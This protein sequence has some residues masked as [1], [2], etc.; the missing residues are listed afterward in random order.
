MRLEHSGDISVAQGYLALAQQ[1]EGEGRDALA[2][3]AYRK[4]VTAAPNEASVHH[5][6]GLFL[7]TRGRLDGGIAAIRRA[8]EL[9]PE[10][11]QVLNNLGYALLASGHAVAARPL[12][13]RA[14][15][16]DSDYEKARRNLDQVERLIAS[17][18]RK[19]VAG[20]G[21]TVTN[22]TSPSQA[23]AVEAR[24]AAAT[25]ELPPA[26]KM[27]VQTAPSTAA[28]TVQLDS[29]SAQP[30]LATVQPST[31]ASFASTAATPIPV[32]VRTAQIDH[33][34]AQILPTRLAESR[35][36]Y[37]NG[38]G[39]EGLAARLRTMMNERG[40]DG[41]RL[42]NL[43][44]YRTSATVIHYRAGHVGA[45]EELARRMPIA[46]RIEANAEMAEDVDLR[47]VIGH[48][49]RHAS[50]CE[51]LAVCSKQ[52]AVQV[53]SRAALAR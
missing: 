4:A 32:A 44:P 33:R 37:V 49:V 36:Q 3:D 52:P 19:P 30:V 1:L 14:L 7:A 24:S 20:G 21:A 42:A 22:T 18:E 34:S 10:R 25:A 48:D 39:V 13:E 41:G 23:P 51:A 27:A 2:L 50:A 9:E 28:L 17:N 43:R 40:V 31:T 45:A 12:L 38:N 46:A 11:P 5:A 6:L 35:V 47:V 53:A 29:A 8:L 26:K 15:A 16:L